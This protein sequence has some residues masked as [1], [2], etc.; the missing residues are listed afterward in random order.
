MKLRILGSAAGG[1]LPQWN[2]GGENS[3]RARAGD[4]AVPARAQ[5]CVAVSAD[6]ARWSLL[7]ASPDLRSQLAAFAPLHPRAGTRDVPLDSVR[8]TSPELDCVSGLLPRR[9]AVT[10]PGASTRWVRDSLIG[11]GAPCR[12]LGP[13]WSGVALD[14]PIHLDR[15]ETLEARFFPVAPKLPSY[16]RELATGQPE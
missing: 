14:R 13:V 10:Y 15:G 12:P 9:R 4:A 16:L 8:L 3:V 2:C 11:N 7:W 1:G 5:T 6:G